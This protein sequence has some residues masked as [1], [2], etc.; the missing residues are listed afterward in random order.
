MWLIWIQVYHSTVALSVL[1][2]GL[3]SVA[4]SVISVFVVS[5]G[6]QWGN[7][8]INPTQC[9]FEQQASLLSPVDYCQYQQGCD[10][11]EYHGK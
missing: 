8:E 6:I 2:L 5:P 4:V 9:F 11:L 3:I 7:V 10:W 1:T